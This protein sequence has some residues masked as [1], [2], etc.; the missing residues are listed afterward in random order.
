M[1]PL[2]DIRLPNQR[3]KIYPQQPQE[4]S[5]LAQT[6]DLPPILAQVLLNRGIDTPE[7]ARGFLDPDSLTMP[8]PMEDFPQLSESVKLLENAIAAGEKIAICG[9]YDADGMTSTALLMRALRA[10]GGNVDYAIP[11]RMQ[12]GYGINERIV[13]EFHAEGVK[14]ILTVDNGIA[15]H[16]PLALAKALGVKVIVTDHHEVPETLP[17]ASAILNPKLIREDSPYRGVAG[18][19]VA[20]I[21]AVSL[22][23]QLCKA[24]ALIKPLR[25]LLTLGTIADLAPLTGI[26]RRWV[27]RGLR[28]LPDSQLTG[29]QA[30]IQVSRASSSGSGGGKAMKPDEIGFRLGPRINAVGR[31]GDP[32]VVIELLTTEDA[33]IALERA[34]QCEQINQQRK[35]MCED[36]EAEAIAWVEDRQIDLQCDRVLVVVNPDWHHGVIGI[37][38]SRL[39]ERYG[40]PVFIGT[41]EDDAGQHIR[42]SARGI[43]EFHVFE[44]LQFCDDLLGKY[45]GHRAAGGFSLSGSNLQAFRDRLREFA[46]RCLQVHHLKPLV[47]IDALA[48]FDRLDLQLYRDIDLLHPCGIEN[49]PPVFWTPNV[50]VVEQ[51]IVGKGHLKLTF[52]APSESGPRRLRAIAWRWGE[53]FPLPPRVDVAYKLRENTWKDRTTLELEVVGLRPPSG[54][55]ADSPTAPMP[56][57]TLPQMPTPPAVSLWIPPSPPVTAQPEW[58]SG[59]IPLET[60]VSQLQGRVLLYGGSQPELEVPANCELESGIP[61][62]PCD[63]FVLWTLPPSGTHMQWLLAKGAPRQVYVYHQLPPL[64]TPSKLR[65]HLQRAIEQT[66]DKP[67]NLLKLGQELWVAPST[68]LA[69]LREFGYPCPQFPSTQSLDRELERLYRWYACSAAQ[70]AKINWAMP[71]H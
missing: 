71:F 33:G 14:I 12:E 37:V 64:P 42:G 39:V 65:S 59:I 27:K 20:Y 31:I 19:G 32:Q 56:R 68:L 23:Q 67:L 50:E 40:V 1:V 15:A 61:R 30:L 36:I 28:Q 47:E 52:A 10:L 44:A 43:P 22:A 4:A 60:L 25:E 45:G 11:S 21:L 63:T 13:R 57:E 55:S 2:T 17:P 29:V 9:D 53:Y 51:R 24:K 54:E 48:P 66:G 38:A 18:V 5:E 26:N 49:P 69:A 34:M 41:Y 6:T 46:N 62:Q 58:L 70:L 7:L 35:Q 3:W 8:S 16:K